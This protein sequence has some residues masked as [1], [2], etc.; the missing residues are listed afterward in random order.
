MSNWYDSE[1]DI[2][3][4]QDHAHET[5]RTR[6]LR[7]PEDN[8][9]SLLRRFLDWINRNSRAASTEGRKGEPALHAGD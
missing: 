3:R 5:S 7:R 6:P 1:M 8:R 4:R 9:P 2:L